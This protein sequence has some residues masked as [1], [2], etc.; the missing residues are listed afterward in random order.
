MAQL[1]TFS[2]H[3]GTSLLHKLDVR[4]KL[5][6]LILISLAILS[7]GLWG[8]II[9]SGL[10]TVLAIHSRMPLKSGFKE[11]RVFLILLLLIMGARMFTVPG[12]AL[13]EI[14]SMAI[15]RQGLISGVLICWRMVIIALLGFFL[16]FS[17]PSSEI[18]AAVERIFKPVA[19]VPG[20]RIATMM[21]LIA[22][23]IPV[24]LNQARETAEAQR[25]RCIEN[26]KNPLYRLARMGLPLIRRTFEQADRLIVAMEARCYSENR[27]DSVLSATRLDWAALIIVLIA[28]GWIVSI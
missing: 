2:F 28:C 18:K 21:G 13:I 8:L 10:I 17:T 23:F 12:T 5:L 11:F 6:F 1:T 16:V 14:Q 24:I 25:A 26:R 7:S 9:F 27:T 22:R 19:F 3:P 15:T 20:K 4:F